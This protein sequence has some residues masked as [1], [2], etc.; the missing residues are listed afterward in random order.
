MKKQNQMMLQ[1]LLPEGS[2]D[3]LTKM[4]I[5]YVLNMPHTDKMYYEKMNVVVEFLE[6]CLPEHPGAFAA[7]FRILDKFPATQVRK[8]PDMMLDFVDGYLEEIEKYYE[9]KLPDKY[10]PKKI[11]TQ[12]KTLVDATGAP[13]SNF[14]HGPTFSGTIEDACANPPKL[15]LV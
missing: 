10:K 11:I 3:T 15:Q 2:C 1:I 7:Y 12:S 13:I 8:I 9:G 6:Q 5:G 4:L 14:E